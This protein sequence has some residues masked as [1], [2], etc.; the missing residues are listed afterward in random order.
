MIRKFR[1]R[2]LEKI[3][4]I[5]LDGNIEA[6]N[7]V[8]ESYWKENYSRV[9]EA[10]IQ[11]E[12]Y[13]YENDHEILGFIGLVNEYIAGL[14]VSSKAQNKGI[15][16]QLIDYV[17]RKRDCLSLDVYKNN[18]LAVE[19]YDRQG[20]MVINESLDKENNEVEMTMQWQRK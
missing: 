14:F 17:K 1:E 13:V 11:A 12:L 20:F 15:G 2:D 7:F 16:Y 4:K 6:H 10:L 19:F 9:K 8:N 18:N 3:M 5:W